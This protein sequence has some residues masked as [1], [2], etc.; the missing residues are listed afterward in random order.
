MDP[1]TE[2]LADRHLL[3]FSRQAAFKACRRRH[4]YAY[5][6]ALRPLVDAK[7]LRMGSAY[8]CGLDVL[9]SGSDLEKAIEHVEWYYSQVMLADADTDSIAVE[10]A[11]V[12][13]LLS[14]YAWRWQSSPLH[15]LASEKAFR[16][17]LLNPRTG[18]PSTVFELAGKID[19]IVC[20][21][22]GRGAVLEHKLVSDDIGVGSDFWQ[23][24]QIDHQIS[25]YVYAGRKLGHAVDT[26]LYDVTRKPTIKPT[27][28]AVVDDLGAKIVLDRNGNRV[29][30]AKG[31]WRQTGSTEEGFTLQTRP[32]TADEWAAK[33]VAD[34]GERPDF[35]FSR[36]EIPRL[37]SEIEEC[38]QELWDIQ[39]T[40]RE[41]QRS[42]RHYR[43]VGKDTCPWCPY[44]GLCASKW[45]RDSALPEGFAFVEN[46]HPELGI[47][48]GVTSDQTDAAAPF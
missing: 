9:K 10:M 3:T 11:T 47:I 41:A 14:G 6:I 45:T 34:I 15:V 31:L 19:G 20:L 36:V 23:R 8:H 18:H 24:L 4:W 22:D 27:P 17:P 48:H 32:M 21:E 38:L 26:V 13:A 1:R 25:L 2:A 35:Y 40:I 5:E 28:V 37:D 33:I 7:A 16:L 46:V 44:W 12:K 29:K 30:T 39:K 43:T 42:G